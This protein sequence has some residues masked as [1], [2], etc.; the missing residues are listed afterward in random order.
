MIR[1]KSYQS[2][3][4]T[5][6]LVATPIGNLEDMTF[7]AVR[8]LSEVD[9]IYAEDTRVTKKLLSHFNINTALRSYHMFNETE[10]T[11]EIIDLLKEGKQLALVTD[12]GLPGISDP[13]Y[14]IAKDAIHEHLTVIVIPGASAATTALLTS[15]LVIEPYLFYGFLHSKQSKRRSEL[16]Q[17]KNNKETIVL[18]ESIHRLKD[19]FSDM[20]D[21]LGDRSV[22]LARELTKKHE[23]IIRGTISQIIP[24]IE[25]LKGEFVI[26]VSGSMVTQEDLEFGNRSFEDLVKHFQSL[27]LKEMDMMKKIASIKGVSKSEIYKEYIYKFKK[28][29]SN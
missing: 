27:G 29:D 22:A 21:I 8:I 23:E 10:K 20:L 1:Q 11:A 17:L 19:T 15:G 12:A 3:N 5:L 9:Y 26:V 25:E 4:G 24:I 14:L 28:K 13:G 6:Y 2:E 7:R 18:Y 16:E